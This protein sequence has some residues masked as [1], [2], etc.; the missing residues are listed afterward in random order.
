M[1][2]WSAHHLFEQADKTLGTPDAEGLRNYAL[3]LREKG[4]PVI[5]SL[6]HLAKIT[7]VDYRVLHATVSRKREN[8]DYRLFAIN[9][10]SG[11]RRFIH[12][13]CSTLSIVQEFINK[14]ILT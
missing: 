7:G 10:R 14:E 3:A 5:F 9:K 11:G 12:A 4:L 13:P 2:T 8:V 6:S 1:E